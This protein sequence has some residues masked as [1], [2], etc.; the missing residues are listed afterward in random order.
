MQHNGV[1]I[2][3]NLEIHENTAGS[4][5]NDSA[6]PGPLYL[7]DHGNPVFYRN[8]WIINKKPQ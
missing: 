5:V 7:Q 2:L 3:E 6:N 8:I 4:Q 1:T